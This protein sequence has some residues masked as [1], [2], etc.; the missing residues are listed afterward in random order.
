VTR[1]QY[2]KAGFV[3]ITAAKVPS[4]PGERLTTITHRFRYNLDIL[5]SS[6]SCIGMEIFILKTAV[7]IVQ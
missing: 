3:S 7:L 6:L 5:F 4:Q 1:F 2:S